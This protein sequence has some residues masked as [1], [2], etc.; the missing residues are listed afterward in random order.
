MLTKNEVIQT[1]NG[2]IET[3]KDGQEGFWTAADGISNPTIRQAFLDYSKQRSLFAGDLQNLVHQIGGTPETGGSASAA[4]RRGWVNIKEA[5]IGKNE[6]N[7]LKECIFAED[8]AVST[9]RNALEKGLP[10][11]IT[12]V[13]RTQFDHIREGHDRVRNLKIVVSE[14]TG[15]NEAA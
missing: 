14:P 9:F 2:L 1:L 15:Q 3:C 12:L 13:V 4:F 10:P 11:D 6:Q 7:V 5:V 8:I